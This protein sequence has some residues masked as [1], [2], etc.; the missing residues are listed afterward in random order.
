[1]AAST[2]KTLLPPFVTVL[3][4]QLLFFLEPQEARSAQLP[5]LL[6]VSSS[7]SRYFEDPSGNIV[8]LTGA[9]DWNFAATMSPSTVDSYLNYVAAHGQNF[10]RVSSQDYNG[11]ALQTNYFSELASRVSKA[12][13]RGIYVEV[14]GFSDSNGFRGW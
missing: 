14:Q 12:A 11:T 3:L 1:M 9:Y 2:C 8:Y 5:G 13:Q 6:H 7:N 10:L 4:F